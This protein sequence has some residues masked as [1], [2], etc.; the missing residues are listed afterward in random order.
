MLETTA[1]PAKAKIK[2]LVFIV[3]MLFISPSLKSFAIVVGYMAW[4][5]VI[6]LP[7]GF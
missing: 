2:V 4:F 3:R 6:L 5:L 7:E 1:A